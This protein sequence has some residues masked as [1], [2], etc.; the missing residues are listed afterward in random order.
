[1]MGQVFSSRTLLL[2]VAV[3]ILGGC[4]RSAHA[5][6]TLDAEHLDLRLQYAQLYPESPHLDAIDK[7]EI[8]KGMNPTQVYLAWGPPVHRF[9]A[10]G[11]QKWIYEFSE[12]VAGQPKLV[13]HLFFER[14]ELMHW[15]IDH[16]YVF[17]LDTETGTSTGDEFKDLPD[18]GGSKQP[19]G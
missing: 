19:G 18:L 16:S 15:R 7:Q 13:A 5:P 10:E 11:E 14:K 1:M 12:K 6:I 2:L 17:F 9:K 4:Q 3:V 8:R